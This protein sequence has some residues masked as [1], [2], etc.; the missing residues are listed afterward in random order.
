MRAIGRLLVAGLVL[1]S[2]TRPAFPQVP[3]GSKF[4]SGAAVPAAPREEKPPER[5]VK[6]RLPTLRV[7]AILPLTGPAAWFGKEIRQGIELAIADLN[8]V[9]AAGP[10]DAV[11]GEEEAVLL[12]RR[13]AEQ[14]LPSLGATLALETAD[15]K[16]Q[17]TKRAADEF[18]RL[19]G[20][21]AV[22]VFTASASPAL[23][24]SR[25]ASARNV[26]VVH[27]GVVDGRFPPTSHVLVHTR[28]SMA[29]YANALVAH[30]EE[31]KVTR[32][33]LLVA[34]DEVGKA[35]RAAVSARW[36]QL[37]GTLAV[38]E[39]L[40]P[41]ASDLVSRLRQVARL[42]PDALVLG[43]RGTD[44]AE[45]AARLREAGYQGA[46]YLLDDDQEVRLAAGRALEGAVILSDTFAPKAGP[47]SERFAEGYKKKFGDTPS[48]YAASAYDAVVL[49]A[50]G[51][52][53]G[54]DGRG[55][56]GGAR[57]REAMLGLRDVPSVYGGPLTL[58]AD[59]VLAR[60]LALFRIQGGKLIF[61]KSLLPAER[62]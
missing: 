47:R 40:T 24:V 53:A 29:V 56:P 27:Q 31:Q 5:E 43:Y 8:A 7:G 2:L 49:V 17:D 4:P 10:A 30:A 41:E 28:P 38:E 35:L 58:R 61:I 13:A 39:S 60:P 46:L 1:L 45:V 36:R 26:L 50:A 6:P 55:V 21:G 32:L 20:P 11:P 14:G 9:E 18:S 37:G 59:G 51:I 33:G 52:R 34:G 16:P 25:L 48:R 3:G 15:V 19:A 54:T 57:L 12:G 44:L 62:S 22:V 23:A 42:A